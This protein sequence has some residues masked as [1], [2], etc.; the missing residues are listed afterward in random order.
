MIEVLPSVLEQKYNFAIPAR[1]TLVEWLAYALEPDPV[2]ADGAI[3]SLY[4]DTPDLAMY[5]QKRN[6]EYLKF[7]VRL[8]WYGDEPPDDGSSFP[9]YIE[10]KRKIGSVR[11]KQRTAVTIPR[12]AVLEGRFDDPAIAGLASLSLENEYPSHSLLMP[13]AHICYRRRRYVDALCDLRIALDWAI[14]CLWFNQEIAP[15]EAPIW[16]PAGVL[17]VKGRTRHLP[18][19]LEPVASL[20]H[21]NSFS[22]YAQCLEALMYPHGPRL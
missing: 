12:A 21:K 18:A 8:R 6:S 5:R 19:S 15:L 7:K 17:E 22:K 2:H 3:H 10:V 4:F 16:L 14:G 1:D 20:L 11:R 9:A 13:L